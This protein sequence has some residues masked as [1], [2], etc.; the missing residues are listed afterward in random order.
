MN[1]LLI[2]SVKYVM[3]RRTFLLNA[4]AVTDND[5]FFADHVGGM[6]KK[7]AKPAGWLGVIGFSIKARRLL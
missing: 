5:E 6:R 3:S 2:K 7:C 1:Y 4:L